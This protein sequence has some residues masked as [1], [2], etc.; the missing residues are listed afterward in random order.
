MKTCFVIQPFDNGK[1]DK[2][3]NDIYFPTIEELGLRPYR[4]DKDPSTNVLI[5]DIE[6]GIR[7]S[8]II[9]ADITLDNPNVWYELG[10]AFSCKKQVVMVCCEEER[11][12][13]FPFDIQHRSIISYKVGSKSDF[14]D[15][16]NKIKA[17][18]NSFLEKAHTVE[19]INVTPIKALDGLKGHEIAIM[20][21]LMERNLGQVGTMSTYSLRDYM[22]KAGFTAIATGVGIATLSKAGL[23]EK[24]IEV[25]EYSN[26]EA[27]PICKLTEKGEEWVLDNQQLITFEKSQS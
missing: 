12:G 6:K 10:Y 13:K 5:D 17:K 7:E 26:G 16:E 15:L 4:I 20:L 23:I 27:Y 25:D 3:F 19:A 2:R 1:F 8:E 14:T 11:N 9:L 18:M 21:I 24:D 22:D